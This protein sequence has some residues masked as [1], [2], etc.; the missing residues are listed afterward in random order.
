MV[1]AAN[2]CSSDD[3][4]QSWRELSSIFR[5]GPIKLETASV[6]SFR[7]NSLRWRSPD[8]ASQT[9]L[10]G[11]LN[12]RFHAQGGVR[13]A[14]NSLP[15]RATPAH[16]A[17]GPARFRMLANTT[18]WTATT[19]TPGLSPLREDDMTQPAA[20]GW[21]RWWQGRAV[22][23]FIA[24]EVVGPHGIADLV[25]A[26]FDS[27]ALR[28]RA[29][30]G[31]LGT[32]DV[33]ALR[34]ILACRRFARSTADLMRLLDL[35]ESGVRRAVRIGCEAGALQ[36]VD[37]RRHLT[38]AGWRPVAR[39]LVAVELKRSDWQR[40]VD[41]LWAYQGW[42]SSAWLVLGKRPPLSAI[43]GLWGMGMGLAYL[44]EDGNTQVVLRPKTKRLSGIASI[45]AG[46]QALGRALASGFDPL[47]SV[48]GDCAKSRGG[49]AV[50]VG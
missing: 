10:Q 3:A 4:T 27:A 46:E 8:T 18:T 47:T 43:E 12:G 40:A 28:S 21:A 16:G 50:P 23:D 48:K 42:A 45:W 22:P 30:A 49:S 20:E 33:G 15:G 32:E 19:T 38:H 7:A 26:Q 39:R 41:Q 6:P 29:T 44:G 14:V 1:L 13:L 11:A 35:S 2:R 9:C 25:A 37:G 5:G 24:R 31:I 17:R 34:A 36:R